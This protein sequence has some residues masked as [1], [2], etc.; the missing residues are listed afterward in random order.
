MLTTSERLSSPEKRAAENGG[1]AGG[2]PGEM[3]G[4]ADTQVCVGVKLILNCDH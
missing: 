1:G 4:V 3:G 2:V